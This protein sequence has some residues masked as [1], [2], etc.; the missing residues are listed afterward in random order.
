[1]GGRPLGGS[2]LASEGLHTGL[3]HRTGRGRQAEAG[4]RQARG[5]GHRSL[6]RSCRQ[7]RP[8]VGGHW[9]NARDGAQLSHDRRHRP[10]GL[11]ALRHAAGGHRRHV[12][13]PDRREQR[14]RAQRLRHRAG[15]AD[16]AHPGLPHD[17]RAQLRRDPARHRFHAAY[18]Q[19][20]G[21]HSRRLEEGGG[22]DH[23]PLR[24]QGN[25]I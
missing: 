20:Q 8:L 12:R 11:Q 25:R 23:R 10:Q 18:R 3:H 16:Q 5:Q 9:R 17:H 13:R 6:C 4:V 21:G 2:L 24:H 19:A 22:C 1:M 15:Q 7:P 14:H